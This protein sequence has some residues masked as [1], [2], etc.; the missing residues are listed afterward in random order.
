MNRAFLLL[1]M[2]FLHVFDDFHLQG[3]LASM[4]QK[5]YWQEHAP[6]NKYRFDYII[7]LLAHGFGW[8]F[9]VMLPIAGM[10]HFCVSAR[11]FRTLIG[12][13]I[14]HAFIDDAKANRGLINLWTD[15]I[16]HVMQIVFIIIVMLP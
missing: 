3:I 13:S 7:S 10:Q 6:Q 14:I 5:K 8:A 16:L 15:Q 9:L 11:F 12:H 2:L 4:K 1:L